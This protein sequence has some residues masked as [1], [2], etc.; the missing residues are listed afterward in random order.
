MFTTAC[1]NELIYNQKFLKI[2]FLVIH[3]YF[4]FKV[5]FC[6]FDFHSKIMNGKLFF[7]L[8]L[9]TDEESLDSPTIRIAEG[10]CSTSSCV[11]QKP[12]SYT[13]RT[14]KSLEQ[15]K[16]REEKQ[17]T[18]ELKL[19]YGTYIDLIPDLKDLPYF[20]L[21]FVDREKS[22]RPMRLQEKLRASSPTT[23]PKR[24]SSLSYNKSPTGANVKS[25]DRLSALKRSWSSSNV[26]EASS[27]ENS[28]A[29]D[30]TSYGRTLVHREFT[31][32]V[33]SENLKLTIK[34]KPSPVKR[35]RVVSSSSSS[36]QSEDSACS[37][38]C[39]SSC[40]TSTTTREKT[41]LKL[42]RQPPPQKG[43]RSSAR[44]KSIVNHT[45][46]PTQPL[47]STKRSKSD[48][49]H[50]AHHHHMTSTLL[51][52]RNRIIIQKKCACCT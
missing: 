11:D 10:E 18:A 36:E 23:S 19:K 12:K 21:L 27:T 20:E 33:S 25:E 37:P 17:I 24:F 47:I 49:H 40:T 34:L 42:Q 2:V 15:K 39:P 38:H 8:D 29:E 31:S 44:L 28:D 50:H 5:C 51:S 1:P 45:S 9:S 30:D 14:R 16:K 26:S 41:R 48:K 3:T 52:K 22:V 13:M 46:N 7:V 32:T 4:V 43:V 35:V 6:V